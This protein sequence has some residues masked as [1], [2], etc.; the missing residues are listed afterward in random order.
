MLTERRQTQRTGL[1]VFVY[2]VSRRGQSRKSR[3]GSCLGL[4]GRIENWLLMGPREL[5]GM[6]GDFLQLDCGHRTVHIY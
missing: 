4:E 6:N 5:L 2:E 3:I 1:G